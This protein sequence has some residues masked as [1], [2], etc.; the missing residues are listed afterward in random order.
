MV[1]LI[2]DK[3]IVWQA[4][5]DERFNTLKANEEELNRIFAEIYGLVGEVSIEVPDDKV[6]VRRADLQREMRSLV[7]YA[8]G[9]MFG[10]YSL[11]KDGLI[12]ANQGDTVVEYLAQVPSPSFLPDDNNIIPILDGEWFKDD[13]VLQFKK[14]LEMPEANYSK[15]PHTLRKVTGLS[16]W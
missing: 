6:T 10:R 2:A 9:C 7:S 8:I 1:T 12:L 5:C 15:F 13:A 16:E 11:D 14:F 3:F 4:E